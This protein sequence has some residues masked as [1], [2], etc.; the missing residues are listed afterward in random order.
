MDTSQEILANAEQRMESTLEK[1]GGD[2]ATIRTGRANP[3][4]LQRVMVD[5]YGTR[6]P[7]L[8]LANCAVPE[9]RMLVVN[10]Y[11]KSALNDIEAAIRNADLGLNPANDGDVIR[12]VFPELT[13]ERRQDYIKM[14]GQYAEEAR[15]SIRNIRR[16]AR[17]QLD[18]LESDGAISEDERSRAEE[19]IDELT[20]NEVAKVDR[21]L[22]GKEEELQQV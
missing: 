9:P 5:Y 1:L 15:I 7:L 19:Q 6:T 11:D 17:D 16:D 3:Q 10:P 18:G 8:Q 20:R 21:Q 12:C 2:F 4:V 22:K 13:K 14:A